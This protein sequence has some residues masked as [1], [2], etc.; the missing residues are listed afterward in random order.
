M[1]ATA[2]AGRY[3][4]LEELGRGAM[5]VVYRAHDPVIGRTVAVKTL[6]VD[7]HGSGLAPDELLRRFNTEARAAGLLS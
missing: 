3:Q 7:E 1:T 6:R 4:L 5:G 2:K